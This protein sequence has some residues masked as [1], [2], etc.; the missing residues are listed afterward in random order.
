M[1][2]RGGAARVLRLTPSLIVCVPGFAL[3]GVMAAADSRFSA[4]GGAAIGA[5]LGLF[6][7]LA[8]GGAL[9]RAV[10]DYCFGPEEETADQEAGWR[11]TATSTTR[12]RCGGS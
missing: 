8:F 10:A 5:T 12:T 1:E 11:S 4:W 3:L 9:P 7:G 2:A 6:F